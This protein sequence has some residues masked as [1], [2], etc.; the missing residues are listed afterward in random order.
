M[1]P[2]PPLFEIIELHSWST[3]GI[4]THPYHIYH[5][6]DNK[7][8]CWVCDTTEG[9]KEGYRY[10]EINPYTRMKW[11]AIPSSIIVTLEQQFSSTDNAHRYGYKKAVHCILR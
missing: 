7:L 11:S 5:I 6:Y 1:P 8:A 2:P 9:N 4:K 10:V 3:Q